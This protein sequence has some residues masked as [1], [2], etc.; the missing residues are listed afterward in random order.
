M[1]GGVANSKMKG[2]IV[3]AIVLGVVITAYVVGQQRELRYYVESETKRLTGASQEHRLETRIQMAR[4]NTPLATFGVIGII[5]MWLS[6]SAMTRFLCWFAWLVLNPD[7]NRNMTERT[8][9]QIEVY[10][11]LS[12]SGDYDRAYE[13][14]QSAYAT[15]PQ[16]QRSYWVE[17]L[18]HAQDVQ[19]WMSR[20]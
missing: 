17:Y 5:V 8:R 16:G 1:P 6:F 15:A 18:K 7:P 4:E 12:D 13:Y 2:F 9:Q 3:I 14:I 19:L 11:E 20:Q 10:R